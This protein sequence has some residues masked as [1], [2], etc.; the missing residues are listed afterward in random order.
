M[1]IKK[2]IPNLLTLGNLLAGCLG[3]VFVMQ[4]NLLWASYCIGISL[5]CDF[6]DGFLARLLH[7]Y[8]EIGKQLDS[9]ADMVSFGILPSFMLLHLVE[10]SCTSLC[11][12]GLGG[13]YK[14]YMVFALALASA[15]RLAKFNIDTR[16]SDQFI[17]VPTP[18]NGLFIASIPLILSFQPAFAVY[19]LHF[20]GLLIYAILM[21]YLMVSELP[22]IA[23]KFKSF[24]WNANQMRY[25]FLIFCVISVLLLKFVAIPLIV[26]SYILLSGILYILNSRQK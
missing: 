9:L 8:S 1:N 12:Y 22:L 20:N 3:L 6:L 26:I 23:F 17:G 5:V 14:P 15:Y 16:Q 21:S 13:F 19:F 18:A 11:Y 25:I 4:G 10:K 2:E 24:A 7:A